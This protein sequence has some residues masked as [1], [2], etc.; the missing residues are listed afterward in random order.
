MM[1]MTIAL[2]R[3]TIVVSWPILTGVIVMAMKNT[4]RDGTGCV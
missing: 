1:P 3:L 2:I 4:N